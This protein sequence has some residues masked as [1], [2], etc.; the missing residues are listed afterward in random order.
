YLRRYTLVFLFSLQISQIVGCEIKPTE[1]TCL[2]N[3]L[4]FGIGKFID[5]LEPISAAASKE[6]SLEKNL[7]KMKLDWVNMKFNFMKY[8]DTDTSILCTVDDIQLLLDDHVIKTQTMCGSP[9]I[10][11]IEA[12]CWKWEE[13]LVRVQEI[14]D[15]WLKCQATW[16]YLEPIF[17]SE[18]I[19][20]QMPEEGRKFAIVDSYWKSLMSQAVKDSRVLMAADQPRMSEKLQEANLLLEDIQKGLNDYLEKKRLFF[21][22]FF[23]LSND[24]LLEIL[25]ETKDPFR[26]Q[27]HLKKCFEGIAKLEFTD[28]LEIV[29][30][31]SSEK[32]TVPFKQKVYPIQAKVT[33]PLP[34]F[35][36]FLPNRAK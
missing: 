26:V 24:E 21:P 33:L 2:S 10:K 29:G 8:R 12:E 9:F 32:E 1:T 15:A 30:M 14:L 25:S 11:P 36:S 22:R 3:M 20:A 23:F 17:S 28:S 6:Y 7:E 5:K 34:T 4:E 19:I 31:I 16:L 35:G 27:P 13:K 18:D